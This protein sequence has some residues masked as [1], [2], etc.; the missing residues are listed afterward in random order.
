MKRKV[1]CSAVQIHGGIGIEEHDG[2]EIGIN[3]KIFNAYYRDYETVYVIDPETG[4]AFFA[5][6]VDNCLEIDAIRKAIE[7]LKMKKGVM[8]KFKNYQKTKKYKV[9][10]EI[11]RL[12]NLCWEL[13][14]KMDGG[15][16][17]G[18]IQR[19]GKNDR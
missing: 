1:F 16:Y 10:S 9:Q 17:N 19:K 7:E 5:Y 2:F 4:G 12:L 14:E 3:G 11:F 6:R 18:F 8:R 13:E 15:M